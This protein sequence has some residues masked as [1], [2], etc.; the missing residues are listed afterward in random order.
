MERSTFE[1]RSERRNMEQLEVR[2]YTRKEMEEITGIPLVYESG[3]PNKDFIGRVRDRLEKWGYSCVTPHGGP[4][5]ITR[6]PESAEECLKEIMFRLF[7]LDTQ[8]GTNGEMGNGTTVFA[9]FLHFMMSEEIAETMPWDERYNWLEYNYGVKA[10]KPCLNRWASRLVKNEVMSQSIGK[11]DAMWWMTCYIDGKK[12]RYPVDDNDPELLEYQSDQ[13]QIYA[14][15]LKQT[16]G[17]WQSAFGMTKKALWQKYQCCYYQCKCL[18]MNGITN[19]EIELVLKLVE[20]I[21]DAHMT[22][23]MAKQKV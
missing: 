15:M 6:K 23:L 18:Q 1:G 10:A 2:G 19:D 13:S 8:T 4:I 20:E 12:H 9:C 21:V 7:D 11:D 3:N 22:M 16:R 17:N 5:I 14:D